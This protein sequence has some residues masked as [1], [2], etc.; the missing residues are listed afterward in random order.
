MELTGL[1]ITLGGLCL[2]AVGGWISSLRSVSS[3]D[4]EK[5]RTACAK[6]MTDRIDAIQNRQDELDDEI[7]KKLDI[8]FRM[9]RAAVQFLPI[10]EKEKA[11]I[12]NE[13][14]TK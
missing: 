1:E 14:G 8:V 3:S 10:G 2:T 5:C 11:E 13:R 6:Q 12:I 7:G 9:L 4:C